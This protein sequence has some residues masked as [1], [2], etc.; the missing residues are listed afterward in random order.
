MKKDGLEVGVI[1]DG[2]MIGEISFIKGGEAIATV[3]AT[4]VCRVIQWSSA[5]L[6]SI[7]MRNPSMDIG[8]KHVFSMDWTRKLMDA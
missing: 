4:N 8:M 5:E 1:R 3:L 6:Q 2:A 7:L